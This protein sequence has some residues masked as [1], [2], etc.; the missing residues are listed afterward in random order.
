MMT[1]SRCVINPLHAIR[2]AMLQ[3]ATGDLSVDAG[4][5]ERHDEIGALAGSF[6]VFKAF[7]SKPY[8]RSGWPDQPS[9]TNLLALNA[10]IEA[11]PAGQA[12]RGFAV[13]A[14]ELSRWP[15]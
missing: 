15:A 13:V 1:L 7:D 14:S 2:D 9:Q 6:A 5:A 12:G 11:A 10:T 3:F 8:W 4:Y